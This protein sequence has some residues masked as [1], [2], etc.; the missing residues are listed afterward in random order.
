METRPCGRNSQLCN[1]DFFFLQQERNNILINL[2]P[3]SSV[4]IFRVDWETYKCLGFLLGKVKMKI[5][6]RQV[7][8]KAG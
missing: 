1:P 3:Q 7:A 8:Q 4:A 2:K 5:R 6:F